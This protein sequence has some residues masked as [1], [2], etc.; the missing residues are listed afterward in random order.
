MY[1]PGYHDFLLDCRKFSPTTLLVF[2]NGD[3]EPCYA[4]RMLREPTATTGSAFNS[5]FPRLLERAVSTNPAIHDGA[6]L[7][8]RRA[9]TDGYF[10]HS[11]SM[12]LFPPPTQTDFLANKGSAYWSCLAMSALKNVECTVLIAS[13]EAYEFRDG[14]TTVIAK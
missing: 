2:H 7:L 4:E 6:I 13:T 1:K 12:R 10:I 3:G 8:N 11:W 9:N 14:D 5:N